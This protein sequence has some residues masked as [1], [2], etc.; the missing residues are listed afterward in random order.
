[1]RCLLWWPR[2]QKD[3]YR[4][5]I[6]ISQ[7]DHVLN[8][9]YSKVLPIIGEN[10]AHPVLVSPAQSMGLGEVTCLD[11]APSGRR[12]AIGTSG[13]CTVQMYLQHVVSDEEERDASVA[14]ESACISYSVAAAT[15]SGQQLEPVINL[16][17]E[18]I[19]VP[20]CPHPPPP[21]QVSID[22]AVIATSYTLLSNAVSE[23]SSSFS[24]TPRV[25]GTRMRTPA[26]RRLVC[27][28]KL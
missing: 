24:T 23:L 21:R 9:I 7:S 2:R 26:T 14:L 17:S 11:V 25:L 15:V 18:P 22:D 10:A 13:G 8:A 16:K 1:M 12:I 27:V 19:E 5:V 28:R 20:Q 4:C 3:I 6:L